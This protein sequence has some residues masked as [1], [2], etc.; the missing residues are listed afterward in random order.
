MCF[1]PMLLLSQA[2]NVLRQFSTF[3]FINFSAFIFASFFR[4]TEICKK[5]D[6]MFDLFLTSLIAVLIVNCFFC[7][8]LLSSILCSILCVRIEFLC[9][10]VC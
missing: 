8:G 5:I 2:L 10:C 1:L 6:F 9:V 4:F 7:F 3:N